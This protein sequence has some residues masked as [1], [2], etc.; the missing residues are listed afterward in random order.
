MH[1]NND[2]GMVLSGVCSLV[3]LAFIR[4]KHQVAGWASN[5]FASACTTLLCWFILRLFM[6][7]FVQHDNRWRHV[8]FCR[9]VHRLHVGNMFCLTLT[10]HDQFPSNMPQKYAVNS[11]TIAEV[12]KFF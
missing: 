1:E 2:Q 12:L 3:L 4:V 9:D 7:L 5:V 10:Y 11:V 6:C 8:S